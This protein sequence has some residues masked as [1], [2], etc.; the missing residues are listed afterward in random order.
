MCETVVCLA[1]FYYRRAHPVGQRAGAARAGR[2]AA[3]LARAGRA[4]DDAC[5]FRPVRR[6]ESRVLVIGSWAP[7]GLL[8]SYQPGVLLHG[9]VSACIAALPG[10]KPCM[11]VALLQACRRAPGA[12]GRPCRNYGMRACTSLDVGFLACLLEGL[13]SASAC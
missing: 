2:A 3:G 6:L 7:P 11:R 5:Y 12:N 4:R 13:Q 9:K 8:M 10:T 1:I